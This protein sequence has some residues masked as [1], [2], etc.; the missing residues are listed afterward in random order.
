[1]HTSA[2]L[3]PAAGALIAAAAVLGGGIVTAVA[4]VWLDSRRAKR[5]REAA[6]EHERRQLR[7]ATRLV[8]EELADS[9]N[10]LEEAVRT[11]AYWP[12]P[13]Q[14]STE[15]WNEYRVVLAE[16]VESPFSWRV[17]TS[18]FDEVNR[19]NWL[20]GLRARQAHP[21]SGTQQSVES[22][23][24]DQTR[25]AWR[26]MRAGIGELERLI[27]V[28]GPASRMLGEPGDVEAKLWPGVPGLDE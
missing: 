1:M 19:L 6:E 21:V 5:E 14:L 26:S 15:V 27:L 3:T 18:A 17:V 8:I 7:L 28:M 16:H 2:D 23:N 25:Q 4:S 10:L 9:M 22:K 24:E 12:A 20:V 11:K 13:R